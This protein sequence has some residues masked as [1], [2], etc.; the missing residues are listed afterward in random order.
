MGGVESTKVTAGLAG[1]V[2]LFCLAIACWLLFRSMNKHLRR[3]RWQEER[4]EREAAERSGEVEAGRVER[5]ATADDDTP[6][7]GEDAP[8][9]DAVQPPASDVDESRRQGE[10]P[11]ADGSGES[12][13]LEDRE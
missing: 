1:F 6:A 13:G 2:V 12:R 7:N 4:E 8:A 11:R 9:N 3:V 10:D 5:A